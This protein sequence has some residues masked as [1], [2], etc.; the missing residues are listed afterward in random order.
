MERAP[1]T[2]A[3]AHARWVA[4]CVDNVFTKIHVH[5]I[6]TE[7][8]GAATAGSRLVVGDWQFGR[9]CLR[10][11]AAA[12]FAAATEARPSLHR[13]LLR[14]ARMSIPWIEEKER[15]ALFDALGRAVR[16]NVTNGRRRVQ[17][18][19]RLCLAQDEH[20]DDQDLL[21]MIL[22]LRMALRSIQRR[23]GCY[24][25]YGPH[26]HLILPIGHPVRVYYPEERVWF[27]GVV[28][29]VKTP[30]VASSS[31]PPRV[32][33]SACIPQAILH[34]IEY[35]YNGNHQWDD[36]QHEALWCGDWVVGRRVR[37][38]FRSA[39]GIKGWFQ[40]QIT[41][42]DPSRSDGNFF[43]IRNANGNNIWRNLVG[44]KFEDADEADSEDLTLVKRPRRSLSGIKSASGSR[45][46]SDGG[47]KY[48]ES[49]SSSPSSIASPSKTRPPHHQQSL[50][51]SPSQNATLISSGLEF[52]TDRRLEAVPEA[53]RMSYL[54]DLGKFSAAQLAD[55]EKEGRHRLSLMSG[56]SSSP[57]SS[58]SACSAGGGFVPCAKCHPN[59]PRAKG[60]SGKCNLSGVRVKTSG[61][62]KRPSPTTATPGAKRRKRVVSTVPAKSKK[63]TKP[64]EAS[65][66]EVR[67]SEDEVSEESEEEPDDS[68]EE[69]ESEAESSEESEAESSEESEAESS[70]EQSS[71]EH[72][73]E[74]SEAGEESSSDEAGSD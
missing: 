28:T 44:V 39:S 5:K 65:A 43:R 70:E 15:I 66:S 62:R 21:D 42:Y 2:R 69:A 58:A 64:R 23:H 53:A 46:S 36:L 20:K 54:E 8:G 63:H 9:A 67:E 35:E 13:A 56:S 24:S 26:E 73:S 3:D 31:S 6:E 11:A 22:T 68:D 38:A 37:C 19:C 55:I 60:H 51:V 17:D 40:G 29:D 52:F 49:S 1:D 57:L 71:D 50:V 32:A 14:L 47:N 27:G 7:R 59:A 48:A 18:A 74:G 45:C 16:V 41:A 12:D 25:E 10:F 4:D 61:S 30:T 72:S 34:C 33:S